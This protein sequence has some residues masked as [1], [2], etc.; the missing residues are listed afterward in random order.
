LRRARET[1]TVT[2]NAAVRFG[3]SPHANVRKNSNTGWLGKRTYVTLRWGLR[4]RSTLRRAPPVMDAGLGGWWWPVGSLKKEGVGQAAHSSTLILPSF[5][6]TPLSHLTSF[7]DREK[8]P[9]PPHHH[10]AEDEME[11]P[12]PVRKSHTNTADLLAWPEGAQQ[13]LADAAT[14]PSNR[15]PHQ[16]TSRA[17]LS[18][19]LLPRSPGCRCLPELLGAGAGLFHLGFF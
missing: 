12:A 5:R 18:C 13:E 9:A 10:R 4:S 6:S 16:V 17:C 11:R 19:P 1:A 2:E 8:T 3:R 7:L 14:P 15:R